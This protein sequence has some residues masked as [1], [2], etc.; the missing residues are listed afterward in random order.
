MSWLFIEPTDVWLFR[1]G[2]PFDAGSDHRARSLFPANPSTIQGALR[3]EL[4]LASGAP[5]PD[6]GRGQAQ[7]QSPLSRAI[8]EIIGWPSETPRFTL[9]GPFVAHQRCDDQGNCQYLRYFPVPAH[10]AK[11]K[12]NHDYIALAPLQ[13]PPFKANW[14]QD[15]LL[16][17]WARTTQILS[18]TTGWVSETDLQVCLNSESGAALSVTLHQDEHL[19]AHESR[20]GVGLDS[21]VKRPQEGLLYQV[22]FVRPRAD[23]G[24]L[25][26]VD[27]S[28]LDNPIQWPA[29]RLLG[30]GGESRS[31]RYRLLSGYSPPNQELPQVDDK[32]GKTRLR[33]YFATPAWF[34]GG[35]T[36]T[37]WG[38]WLRGRDL[39]LMAAA[40][41]RAQPIGGARIDT[42]SQASN[43][44]KV[45][46]RYVPAGSVFYFEADGA[47]TYN[48]KPV[49]DSDMDGAIG[50]GQ[51][52]LGT[53]DYA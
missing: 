45:M 27:D 44:Q 22:E 33:L 10:I 9:R 30:I 17:L 14:P 51:V 20:F 6:F 53:W 50:Y 11:V 4:L 42:D 29:D 31:G 35:W 13:L 52:L 43:F 47:V 7:A 16:P 5:L 32:D 46:Q 39:R 40:V 36:A 26:E 38:S 34:A 19:F 15:D 28:Q 21:K 12:G 49:T 48:G 23:V 24:L 37:D 8:S 3:S 18:E 2:R 41:R 1:D 25:V